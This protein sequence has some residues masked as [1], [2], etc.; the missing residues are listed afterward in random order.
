MHYIGNFR[1]KHTRKIWYTVANS[2]PVP[3]TYA[4]ETKIKLANVRESSGRK[5]VG[6]SE[7]GNNDP[8][9]FYSGSSRAQQSDLVGSVIKKW[10]TYLNIFNGHKIQIFKNFYVQLSHSGCPKDPNG[11]TLIHMDLFILL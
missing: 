4:R 3:R 9:Y 5:M 1:R 8:Q 11:Y 10:P 7:V 2:T 6:K